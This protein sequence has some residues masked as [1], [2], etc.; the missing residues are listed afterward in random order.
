M[1][2]DDKSLEKLE[3]ETQDNLVIAINRFRAATSNLRVHSEELKD[4]VTSP[5]RETIDK[6][7]YPFE[8]MHEGRD[9]VEDYAT[10]KPVAACALALAGGLVTSLVLLKSGSR[11][12][13]LRRVARAS[14]QNF[15]RVP[16]TPA[17]QPFLFREITKAVTP[18]LLV[19]LARGLKRARESSF[20]NSTWLRPKR[21]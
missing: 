15:V 2:E 20:T 17:V 16:V 19:F 13:H 4:L 14:Y 6:I 1:N 18:Y 12:R 3:Q 21:R 10:R 11:S 8:R 9:K 5:V 7:K